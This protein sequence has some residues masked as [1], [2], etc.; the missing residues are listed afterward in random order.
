MVY[1][2]KMGMGVR[3][4]GWVIMQI[5]KTERQMGGMSGRDGKGWTGMRKKWNERDVG[6]L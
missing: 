1:K 5:E 4:G 3:V 2:V 6:K